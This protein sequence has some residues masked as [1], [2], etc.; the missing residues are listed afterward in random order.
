MSTAAGMSNSLAYAGRMGE[1]LGNK[2]ITGRNPFNKQSDN[3][4]VYI[5]WSSTQIVFCTFDP[6]LI[7]LKICVKIK[8][9]TI[10]SSNVIAKISL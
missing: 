1:I 6:R 10:Y 7:E 8:V 2:F 5:F 9:K 3:F 4:V